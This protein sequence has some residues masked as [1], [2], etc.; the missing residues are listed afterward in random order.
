MDDADSVPTIK[1]Q[2]A[3]RYFNFTVPI[4]DR[5]KVVVILIPEEIFICSFCE[6][7]YVNGR[8]TSQRQ[9]ESST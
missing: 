5:C 2:S 1:L 7:T 3:K 8:D 9:T 6:I 4:A